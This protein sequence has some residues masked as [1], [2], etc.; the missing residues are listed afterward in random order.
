MLTAAAIQ[1]MLAFED[2]VRL[3]SA[4]PALGVS[5]LYWCSGCLLHRLFY[6]EWKNRKIYI[7]TPGKAMKDELIQ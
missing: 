1:V 6:R 2:R 5:Q 3:L 4:D 7:S